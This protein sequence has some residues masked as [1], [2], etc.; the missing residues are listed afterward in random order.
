VEEQ[1]PALQR[2]D[3]DLG[4]HPQV[5]QGLQARLRGR[6]HDEPYEILQ[7][8]GSVE[9]N[10]EEPGASLAAAPHPGL[11]AVR[12]DQSRAPGRLA[13]SAEHRDRAATDEPAHVPA[14]AGRARGRD[15]AAQQ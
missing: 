7:P 10:N 9:Y 11:P 5:Q 3:A 1:P 8:G 14:H 2:E 13:V 15:A 12:L 4:R 6:R